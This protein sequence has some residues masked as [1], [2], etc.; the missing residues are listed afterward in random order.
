MSMDV[1]LTS[2]SS[3]H[4]GKVRKH[5]EDSVFTSVRDPGKGEPLG[6]LIVADGVGGQKAG[7]IASAIAVDTVYEHMSWFIDRD[8]ADDTR[9]TGI[10][11]RDG[12]VVN[13]VSLI[14]TRLKIAIQA[15]NRKILAYAQENPIEAGNMGTTLTCALIHGT[16][17]TMAHIGDSRCYRFRQGELEQITE[18]HSFVGQMVRDGQLTED[19]YYIHPRRNVITRALGQFE[20]PEV[21]IWTMPVETDDE[22]LLCSDGMWEMVRNPAIKQALLDRGDLASTADSLV[23]LANE[24]GGS[25]NISVVLGRISRKQ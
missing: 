25:D 7:D 20:E 18:D 23:K 21:D 22:Y 6:L 16:Q 14:E 19:A 3:T 4:Q 2:A 24:N 11:N 12:E 13:D 9:P 17:I 15:A 1:I 10:R 5:N 8:P